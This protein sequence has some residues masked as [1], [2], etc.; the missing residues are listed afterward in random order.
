MIL[1]I[2]AGFVILL[3]QKINTEESKMYLKKVYYKEDISSAD[4]AKDDGKKV[5]LSMFLFTLIIIFSI[6]L[7]S[8]NFAELKFM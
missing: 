4:H 6:L 2:A 7:S 1:I 3:S 8:V 5:L